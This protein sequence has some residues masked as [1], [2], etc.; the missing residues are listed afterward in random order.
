MS[1]CPAL[2][3][4]L[5]ALASTGEEP[6]ARHG[7]V[8][9]GNVFT[10]CV[11]PIVWSLLARVPV[12]V[13]VPSNDAG[14]P[15]LFLEALRAASPEVSAALTLVHFT[16]ALPERYAELAAEVDV[17]SVHGSD[18]TV[19]ALTALTPSTTELVA[20]GHGLGLAVI[21]READVHGELTD[22]L[23]L[24]VAAYDQHGCLSPVAV[25]VEEGGAVSPRQLA[26]MLHAALERLQNAMPRGPLPEDVGAQQVQW[27]GVAAALHELH[28]GGTHA[29]SF[30]GT[31]PIRTTPGHRNIAVHAIA[32]LRGLRARVALHGEHLKALGIAGDVLVPATVTPIVSRLGYMHGAALGVP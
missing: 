2:E 13:K 4:A 29:V 17:M 10:A 22:A 25:L 27:R 31:G 9:A 32:D 8:L 12:T 6:V 28:D 26:R 14:L 1:N 19:A 20:H 7:L 3:S 15:A 16:R 24:D 21:S 11:R 5:E 23:A 18:S 30:E